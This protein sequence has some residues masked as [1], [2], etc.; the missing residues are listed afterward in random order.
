MKKL[1]RIF[2]FLIFIILFSSCENGNN[3]IYRL[4][5]SGFEFNIKEKYVKLAKEEGAYALIKDDNSKNVIG[6]SLSDV[7]YIEENIRNN[8]NLKKDFIENGLNVLEKKVKL[9]G[10]DAIVYTFSNDEGFGMYASRYY[11]ESLLEVYAITKKEKEIEKLFNE[12]VSGFEYVKDNYIISDSGYKVSLSGIYSNFF[13]TNSDFGDDYIS[14]D[15]KY[16]NSEK[17]VSVNF[18][19]ATFKEIGKENMT[20]KELE[21]EIEKEGKLIKNKEI[22]ISESKGILYDVKTESGEIN[23]NSKVIEFIEDNKLIDIIIENNV[24][25]EKLDI[26]V[27]D[28]IKGFKKI[29]N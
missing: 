6:Y 22:K 1:G 7:S 3:N 10:K 21:S 8:E 12:A 13:D 24:N 9:L 23:K 5:D 20:L 27:E 15:I 14:S 17:N 16:I 29:N 28:I 11:G 4:S 18:K 19:M 26:M 25:I 2:V